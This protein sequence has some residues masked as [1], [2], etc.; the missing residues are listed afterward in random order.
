MHGFLGSKPVV[1]SQV[2]ASLGPASKLCMDQRRRIP[3]ADVQ[4]AC[5]ERRLGA[6]ND[7]LTAI[8]GSSLAKAVSSLLTFC[9]AK[10][11]DPTDVLGLPLMANLAT[12]SDDG[13]PRN[14]PMWF[15][16]ENDAIWLLGSTSASSVKRVQKDPRCAIEIVHFDSEA[17][18]LLHLGLRG[19]ASIDPMSPARFRRLLKKYLGSQVNW[20]TWFIENVALIEDPDGRLI[21]LKPD[22]FYTNNVSYFRTGPDFAWPPTPK[23]TTI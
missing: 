11:F 3:K 9:M 22:S 17:G 18:V 2:T 8:V 1:R 23:D 4:T 20:N 13:S 19:A 12:I 5:S 7:I 15:I 10:K 16:W 14:A 6:L 21:K